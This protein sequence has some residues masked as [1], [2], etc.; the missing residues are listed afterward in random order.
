VLLLR[1]P[2]A[3]CHMNVFSFLI[4][5]CSLDFNYSFFVWIL[6]LNC[7]FWCLWY[8]LLF[9]F[10]SQVLILISILD[11]SLDFQYQLFIV[12]YSWLER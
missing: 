6:I 10:N 9:D 2:A 8:I 11:C 5:N 7:S 1:L 12:H 3:W 4:L